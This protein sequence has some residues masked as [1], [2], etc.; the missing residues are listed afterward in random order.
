[1]ASYRTKYM[2]LCITKSFNHRRII[3][4]LVAFT[5]YCIYLAE[6][7]KWSPVDLKKNKSHIIGAWLLLVFFVGGQVILYA[8]QHKVSQFGF[9]RN[10]HPLGQT[11]TEKCSLCDAMH[12]NSMTVHEHSV[13]MQ[14]LVAT[15]YDYKAVTYSFVSLS[16]ILSPG[17][18]PPVS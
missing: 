15:H 5:I 11:V 17:R 14:L 1:M 9:S 3:C 4:S 18:A 2:A 16:L 6:S 7:L 8:H 13:V 12:F 10:S